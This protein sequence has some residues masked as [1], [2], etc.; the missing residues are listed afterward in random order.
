MEEWKGKNKSHGVMSLGLIFAA[1][2]I[3]IVAAS[4]ESWLFAGI[5]VSILWTLPVA[6]FSCAKCCCRLDCGHVALGL[7]TRI[8]PERRPGPYTKLEGLFSFLPILIAVAYPQYWLIQDLRLLIAFWVLVAIAGSGALLFVCRDCA[9]TACP[10]HKKEEP[11]DK[12]HLPP[13]SQDS[14]AREEGSLF[15]A[16][17]AHRG[18]RGIP[19]RRVPVEPRLCPE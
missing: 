15:D 18:Q 14:T 16:V 7:I 13:A 5:G 10:F 8:L 12:R 17:V 2:T 4:R 11:G 1:M 9:N 19:V 3:G 6:W